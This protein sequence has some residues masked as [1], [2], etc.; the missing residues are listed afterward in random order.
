MKKFISCILIILLASNLFLCR[1]IAQEVLTW[2]DCL[3]EAA[4]NHP[5][6]LAAQEGMKQTEA[7]KDITASTLF[8]QLNS[9]ISASTAKTSSGEGDSVTH[10]TADSYSYGVS[11]SQLLFDGLKT[12]NNVN[13][14]KENIKASQQ[15]Y[16]FTSSQVRLRLRTAFVN[17]LRAQELIHVTEEIVK[18]RKENYELITLRYESGYEHKGALLTAEANLAQAYFEL[19]QAKRDEELAQWQLTKEMGRKAFILMAVKAD[20]K[21]SDAAKE[22]PDFESLAKNHPS[23]QQL[24]AQKNAA[25]F[26][27][28]SSYANFL[29]TLS[30][31]AGADR[32]SPHWLPKNDQWNLGLT[33]SL[34]IFEGGLRLAQVSQAKALF[35]Q[36]QENERSIRDGVIVTLA[37]TWTTLQ[38]SVEAVDVQYKSLVAAEERA[39]IAE[40][41]YSTGFITYDNWTIIED[42]LVGA[43]RQYLEAQANSLLAEANWIQAK[44]EVLEYAQ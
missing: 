30:A 4:K 9:N 5:D 35:N 6:L 36:L 28:K 16:R 43:K 37:Q 44:G 19:A 12:I 18:I 33:V 25:E 26:G 10:R 32:S 1:S 38:D 2:Q 29:P 42:N 8:P 41:Q 31:D 24:T 39:K 15:S 13:A 20:F 23:L 22:K 17:L 3:K 21:V 7:A 11:G 14:A 27:I 40:A 34:P